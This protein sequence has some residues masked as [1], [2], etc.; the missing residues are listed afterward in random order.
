MSIVMKQITILYAIVRPLCLVQSDLW[1]CQSRLP[2]ARR[3][4][5][6][7]WFLRHFTFSWWRHQNKTLAASLVIFAGNSE[8][9]GEFPEQSRVTRRFD[10]FF[11]LCLNKRLSKQWWVWWCV[12]P[13]LPLWRHCNALLGFARK[14]Y[15]RVDCYLKWPHSAIFVVELALEFELFL[16]H[17]MWNNMI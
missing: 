5:L 7:L 4:T 3:S 8:V 6:Q 10:V 12:T 14:M 2:P 17:L 16:F 11:A 1:H 15:C 9:T 13:S